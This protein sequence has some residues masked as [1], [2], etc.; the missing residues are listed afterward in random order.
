V[1]LNVRY[2]DPFGANIHRPYDAFEFNLEVKPGGNAGINRVTISG[3]LARRI[4]HDT[5]GSELLVGL[6]H[7]YDYQDLTN[8]EFA[9]QSL[10]RALLYRRM[11]GARSHIDLS[12]HAEG[13]VLGAIS[14][15]QGHYWRRDY[16]LGP[17]A[18]G[19]FRAA[20]VRGGREWVGLDSRLVWLHSVHGSG[21]DHVATFVRLRAAVPLR[22]S[23]GIGA[24]LG[25]IARH[26]SYPD[27]S[28]VTQRTSQLRGYLAWMPS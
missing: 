8:L 28:R 20:F 18:G 15:D 23:F 25:M 5:S 13:V 22:G 9:G 24:D 12:V 11:V 6:F 7:H 2:R 27:F 10:S 1:E 4:L 16:D 26:S 3:L 14:S 19:R 21:G 17:G